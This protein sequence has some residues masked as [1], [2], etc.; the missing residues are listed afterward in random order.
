MS[1]TAPVQTCTL[2]TV[3]KMPGSPALLQAVQERI[4]ILTD[5]ELRAQQDWRPILAAYRFAL[6]AL[7]L[8]RPR[9]PGRQTFRGSGRH[10]PC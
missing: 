9:P 6:T 10:S 4:F 3:G 8:K 1:K 5:L 7:L 2:D